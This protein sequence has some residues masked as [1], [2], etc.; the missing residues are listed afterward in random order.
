MNN[1]DIY[2]L[3]LHL[4]KVSDWNLSS[5]SQYHS[6]RKTFPAMLSTGDEDTGTASTSFVR[7]ANIGH[8][9]SFTFQNLAGLCS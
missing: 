5:V 3:L 1:S 9:L 2:K 6:D 7:I 4:I 8:F